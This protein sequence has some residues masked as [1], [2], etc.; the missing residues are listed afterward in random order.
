MRTPSKDD[1]QSSGC[2]SPIR[3]LLKFF[4]PTTAQ[5]VEKDIDFDQQIDYNFLKN[6]SPNFMMNFVSKLQ[7]I[8]PNNASKVDEDLYKEQKED[9]DDTNNQFY[10]GSMLHGN[11]K[12]FT[13]SPSVVENYLDQNG[14]EQEEENEETG[15]NSIST[16]KYVEETISS[17]YQSIWQNINNYGFNYSNGNMLAPIMLSSIQEMTALQNELQYLN[18]SADHFVLPVF[19]QPPYPIEPQYM[20]NDEHIDKKN[21]FEEDIKNIPNTEQ[22]SREEKTFTTLTDVG[23]SDDAWSTCTD[24]ELLRKCQLACIETE[25][26][27]QCGSSSHPITS[28]HSNSMKYLEEAALKL[29][30]SSTRKQPTHR[31]RYQKRGGVKAQFQC[32]F[33]NKI[34][35]RLFTLTTHE[36]VHTGSKP[37]KCEFCDQS[38]R[39]SGT[40]RNHIRA[41]HAKEK[42]YKCD[43]CSKFFAH[44]SSL[45][46]HRRIHTKEKP[47][48]CEICERKFTDRATFKKHDAIHS[49]EKRFRCI[50]CGKCLTQ[51][52]NLK[53]HIRTIH[54]DV[55][56]YGIDNFMETIPPKKE[57]IENK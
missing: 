15:Q 23:K 45:V 25:S 10:P 33:C 34:F 17:S 27:V 56:C 2:G 11:Q 50:K 44:K 13:T 18:G 7:Q 28:L 5:C 51:Y 38:F 52:S 9:K 37:Y 53:R 48:Q 24:E 21:T 16:S 46:V 55:A 1:W 6:T 39:Q 29:L 8:K 26:F 30:Q 35:N 22:D 42:P 3:R 12:E 20:D 31:R 36:R 57:I 40:K 49:R 47:Y 32:Q 4:S 19:F 41:V 43:Y 54:K 14:E